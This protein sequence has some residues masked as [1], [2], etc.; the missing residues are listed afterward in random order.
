MVMSIA[1]SPPSTPPPSPTT[2]WTVA[3][4][5]TWGVGCVMALIV[6]LGWRLP[7]GDGGSSR[8]L[9]TLFGTYCLMHALSTFPASIA[10]SREA[11]GEGSS[12]AVS[13]LRLLSA[14]CVLVAGSMYFPIGVELLA[15]RQSSV[16]RW[17][18]AGTAIVVVA[19][20][21]AAGARHSSGDDATPI[22]FGVYVIACVIAFCGVFRT[23]LRY[24]CA[25]PTKLL[26]FSA[27]AGAIDGLLPS[28]A[29][30]GAPIWE[31]AFLGRALDVVLWL[32]GALIAFRWLDAQPPPSWFG[33]FVRSNHI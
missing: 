25:W 6:L 19:A 27:T 29:D 31:P 2:V 9:R 26:S 32:P 12:T 4:P 13:D 5:I 21:I 23:L 1:A 11:H 8:Y 17:T 15:P 20:A 3:A 10:A 24:R 22:F 16:R 28:F 14:Y 30:M 7:P 33:H 18:M